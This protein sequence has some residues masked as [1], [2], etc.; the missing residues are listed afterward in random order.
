MGRARWGVVVLALAL[1]VP[2]GTRAAAGC[3]DADA[4]AGFAPNGSALHTRD[5]TDSAVARAPL[6]A[7]AI[8]YKQSPSYVT[9][10]ATYD[11]KMRCLIEEYVLPHR[12]R[13]VN[14]VVFNEDTGFATLA[15]GTA[16]TGARALADGPKPLSPQISDAAGAPPYAAAAL[17]AAGAGHA[18][19]LAAY[20]A[21]FP[22]EDPRRAILTAATD[23]F[24]RTFMTTFS[25]IARDYNLYVAAANNQ[26]NF[27]E[28]TNP[29]DIATLWNPDHLGEQP[30][31][32]VWK[33]TTADV[34]NTAFMWGPRDVRRLPG[35]QLTWLD[36]QLG[37][38]RRTTFARTTPSGQY[39]PRANLLAVNKKVPLTSIEQQFLALSD[40]DVSPANT[41]PYKIPALGSAY[42][43]GFAISLPAFEYGG[44]PFGSPRPAQPC[45]PDGSTWMY[46]LD[47]RGVN[48]VLQTEANPGPWQTAAD[49][50]GTQSVSWG[51][52]TL[53]AVTDPAVHFS[54]L[55][56]PMMTGNLVD[57]PF[58]GQT[59]IMQRGR[60]GTARHYAGAALPL[61]DDGP[62]ARYAGDHPE[63]L[64][65][66]PWVL[67]DGNPGSA[68]AER[69]ARAV[70]KQRAEDMRA[71]SGS[72]YENAYLET[73]IYADLPL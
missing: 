37:V 62:Y 57:L 68:D 52:S 14:L 4:G 40:G 66:A 25:R 22:T 29:I 34:W 63:F 28:S 26:A 13:G 69:A 61:P 67:S 59:S 65:L 47:A 50:I 71:G 20:R 16:G 33:A 3:A 18:R 15:L 64:A 45:A 43:F 72:P 10:A 19:A 8:Q 23:T 46:C 27:T 55:V 5:V 49:G 44:R 70:L 48:V 31:P 24:V 32:A 39:D 6:R 36:Q 56:C 1:M 73:A 11:H 60:V 12:G 38:P 9:D 7:F 41:G 54:Y 2:V 17:V 35:E 30:P 58:D 42:R 21:L 53:R 51:A